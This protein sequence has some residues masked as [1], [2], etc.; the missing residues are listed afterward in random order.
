MP[1]IRSTKTGRKLVFSSGSPEGPANSTFL[2]RSKITGRMLYFKG[3]GFIPYLFLGRAGRYIEGID[4]SLKIKNYVS[5]PYPAWGQFAFSGDEFVYFCE[6]DRTADQSFFIIQK[7]RKSDWAIETQVTYPLIY[8]AYLGSFY[9]SKNFIFLNYN[10]YQSST[11]K[12]YRFRK[13]DL[14]LDFYTEK[15][16]RVGEE[17]WSFQRMPFGCVSD[18]KFLYGHINSW[19][20]AGGSKAGLGKL[21]FNWNYINCV[22]YAGIFLIKCN[23]NELFGHSQGNVIYRYSKNLEYI[24]TYTLPWAGEFLSMNGFEVDEEYL[25]LMTGLGFDKTLRKIKLEDY[26]LVAEKHLEGPSADE[27]IWDFWDD[28]TSWSV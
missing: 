5:W 24:D 10:S 2:S 22:P 15:N 20:P 19:T 11:Y 1:I 12:F 9:E 17:T 3:V 6:L 28:R 8:Q 14:T 13:S 18:T 23:K 7:V 27:M 25:Y 4:K 26:S 16:G 21:D